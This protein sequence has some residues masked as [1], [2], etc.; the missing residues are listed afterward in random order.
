MQMLSLSR[1]PKRRLACLTAL[2]LILGLMAALTV[3]ATGPNP[4]EAGSGPWRTAIEENC[5]NIEAGTVCAEWPSAISNTVTVC[6]VDPDVV[7]TY[8]GVGQ[9]CSVQL[10]LRAFN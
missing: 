4:I 6:C 3:Q 1:I 8:Q 7:G 5:E 2:L 10:T 9:A